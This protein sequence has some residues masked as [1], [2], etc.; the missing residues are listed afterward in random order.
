MTVGTAE[1]SGTINLSPIAKAPAIFKF[2]LM[3]QNSF[4]TRTVMG[5]AA[6]VVALGPI[7]CG[8]SV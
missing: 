4:T 3:P 7:D 2:D 5:M 8:C 6:A 1:P